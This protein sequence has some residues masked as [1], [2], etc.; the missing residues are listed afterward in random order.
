M[1]ILVVENMHGDEIGGFTYPSGIDVVIGNP[2]AKKQKKRYIESDLNRSFNGRSETLEERRAKELLP[3]I[4]KY[5]FVLDI[6][7]TITGNTNAVISTH[8]SKKEQEAARFLLAK[9]YIYIPKGKNSLIYH[10]KNGLSLELG[11]VHEKN[12]Y[13]KSI[14][15]FIGHLLGKRA[16]ETLPQEWECIGAQEKP[17]D[18]TTIRTTLKNYESVSK[19]NVIASADG[20]EI[21]ASE[22]FTTFLW[23][24][25]QYENILGFKLKTL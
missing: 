4:E 15:N 10:T 16:T 3:V 1:K 12:R 17:K 5:D 21:T 11:G 23:G 24:D 25:G 13:Q 7:S 6:H 14:D 18:C 2:E 19:G 22:D 20:C 8:N 9:N